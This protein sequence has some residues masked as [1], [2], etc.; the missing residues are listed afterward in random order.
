MMAKQPRC[1]AVKSRLAADLG[2]VAATSIYRTMMYNSI[3]RL[4]RD[5][6]WQFVL[7]L[8]P[9]STLNEPL[10]PQ[11]IPLIGQGRGGL[12][13][14]MQ[15]I[16]DEMPPGKVIII[17]SDIAG[18]R[19]DHTAQAFKKLGTAD[20]VFSPV[21]DGGYSLVGM[22]RTPRILSIFDHVRWSSEHTLKDTVRN[23]AGLKTVYVEEMADIDTGAD[24]NN[25]KHTH[26]PGRLCL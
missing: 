25:W 13:E 23:L 20:A 1:G 2:S 16:M 7:S 22:K 17:G 18:M 15:R 19:P 5:P 11:Y 26:K 4:S 9:E 3:A 24:W 14:R 8:T 12:G 10:W 21:S 6:R